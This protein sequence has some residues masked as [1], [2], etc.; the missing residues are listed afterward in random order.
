MNCSIVSDH[1]GALEI[2]KRTLCRPGVAHHLA[3]L[4][5][6]MNTGVVL[7]EGGFAA[8]FKSTVSDG[9]KRVVCDGELSLVEETLGV[10]VGDDRW[11]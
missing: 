2:T 9:T 3:Q 4:S 11:R 1:H 8:G 5:L 7:I 10:S 6:E